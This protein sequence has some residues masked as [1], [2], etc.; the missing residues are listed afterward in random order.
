MTHELKILRKYFL[1]I[2]YE[3]KTFEIRKNDRD[4]H[5]GDKLILKEWNPY[6]SRYTGNYTEATV[7]YI[8]HGNGEYGLAE[9]TWQSGKFIGLAD[10]D[11]LPSAFDGKTN[12]GVIISLYPNLK[13][14]I[15]NGRVVTT[16]GVAS[17]F[18][19]DWWN[20]PYKGVSE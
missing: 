15:R 1:D 2:M 9:W 14:T 4:F 7:D 8:H 19:L 3:H 11:S 13:Y 16:I 10:V 20:A 5:V 6:Q 12:G 18:D 17:S